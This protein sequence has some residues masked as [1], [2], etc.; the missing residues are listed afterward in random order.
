MIQRLDERPDAGRIVLSI[1]VDLDDVVKSV[2]EGVGEAEA[3][4][5]PDPEIEGKPGNL[6]ARFPRDFRSLVCRT[7]VDHEASDA[8]KG[9]VNLV[10]DSRNR[11]ILVE[12]RHDDEGPLEGAIHE[13]DL[14]NQL[15]A[16]GKPDD[17]DNRMGQVIKEITTMSHVALSGGDGFLGWHTRCAALSS[18]KDSIH[19]E[20]GEGFVRSTAIDAINESSRL[21]HIAGVNRGTDD[22]VRDGNLLFARQIS[23]ALEATEAPPPVVVYANSTQVG[24]GSVYAKAKEEAA[25]ILGAAASRVGAEFIDVQFPNL[26]GEH[27]KPFYN[28]VVSTF[29]HLLATG[30]TPMIDRDKDMTLLHAQDAADVL[31]GES[32]L[33]DR[34]TVHATVTELLTILT[35]ISRD[36][37]I[38]EI[39][40]LE[41]AFI[42]NL[43]NTYRSFVF[44]HRRVIPLEPHADDRGLLVEMVRSHGG[45][46]QVVLSSTKPGANRADHFHR[47]KFERITLLSGRGVISLRRLFSQEAIDIDVDGSNPVAVDVPTLWTHR[48]DNIGTEDVH[49]CYWVNRLFDPSDPDTFTETP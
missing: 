6:G 29:C 42:R 34:V 4:R 32:A 31:L 8:W 45:P 18:G 36:Y 2:C 23:E 19:I 39:P 28:S 5:T 46:G 26:F 25:G 41:S 22:E 48:I 35:D 7:V 44:D 9:L 3:H 24:N 49:L 1:R 30:G 33:E 13:C 15:A 12:R 37:S 10:D 20:V 47:R 11:R 27:G 14:S 16:K 43:F 38:G 40:S 21:L 17:V